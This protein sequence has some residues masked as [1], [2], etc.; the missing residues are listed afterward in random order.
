MTKDQEKQLMVSQM[1]SN[2][3]SLLEVTKTLL[4]DVFARSKGE[5]KDLRT[6]QSCILTGLGGISEIEKAFALQREILASKETPDVPIDPT[7][8]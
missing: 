8:N 6:L 1:L 3:I 2:S 7:A 5:E 4:L